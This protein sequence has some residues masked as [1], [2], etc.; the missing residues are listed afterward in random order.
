[1]K[2]H[3]EQAWFH[4]KLVD[5]T[6]YF[7]HIAVRQSFCG[8]F[9]IRFG[10]TSMFSLGLGQ[11]LC[12]MWVLDKCIMNWDTTPG[13]SRLHLFFSSSTDTL[14]LSADVGLNPNEYY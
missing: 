11:P 1:M 8:P 12:T 6:L 7:F 14:I 9:K 4:K 3:I 10:E 5:V 13:F 2:Y